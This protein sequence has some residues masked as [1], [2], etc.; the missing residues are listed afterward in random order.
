L[1]LLVQEDE[2]ISRQRLADMLVRF[3]LLSRDHSTAP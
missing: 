1:E 2:R 3:T